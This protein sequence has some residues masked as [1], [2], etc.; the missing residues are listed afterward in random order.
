VGGDIL[1]LALLGAALSTPKAN[2]G[3]IA[4]A[5]AAV[6][7]V[8][9]L[10]VYSGATL[11]R[12]EQDQTSGA[13]RIVKAITI[14]R[15][16]EELYRYWR[17]FQNL[18]RFMYYLESVQVTGE[19]RSHWVTK[20]PAGSRVEWDAEIIN[21]L[22]NQVIAWRSLE[23]ADVENAGSVRFDRAPGNRGTVVKV[24]MEFMPPGG[25]IGAGIARLFGEDPETQVEEDL[26]RFKQVIETGEVITTEG[27]PAGRPSSKSSKY[28]R[29]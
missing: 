16:P 28:D 17:D 23:G 21:D 14:N 9:A 5:T 10:D 19:K 24:V 13:T 29:P 7:G 26:R 22:P 25:V 1:D 15:P 27:Q 6:A 11:R 4:A 3:R 20:G 2:R 12:R 8:T 18:P